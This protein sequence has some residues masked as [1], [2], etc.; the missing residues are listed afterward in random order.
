MRTEVTATET[1]RRNP[2]SAR[3]KAEWT[4]LAAGLLLLAFWGIAM[5]HRSAGSRGAIDAFVAQHESPAITGADQHNVDFAL[6]SEKRIKGYLESLPVLKNEPMA[7]L[8]VNRLKIKAPVFSGTDELVLNRGLG[9][10][11]GTARPGQSGNSGIAG[12]RDGFFR[13]LKA[14]EVGDAIDL[15]TGQS[16]L[17]YRVDQIEIVD[18][19][20]VGV[21]RPRGAASL[22]LVTCYPFYFVGDAPQRFI[23]HASLEA[24]VIKDSGA[25]AIGA[26]IP[27]KEGVSK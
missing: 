21:L 4:A 15:N 10:I 23:V 8:E 16:R 22:T 12:H 26:A 6:W 20:N 24:Q 18:P 27:I 17:T 19:E 11:R 14:V 9:W 3:R 1:G 7:V 2:R 13:A 25:P 5:L